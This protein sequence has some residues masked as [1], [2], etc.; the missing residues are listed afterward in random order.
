MEKNNPI[1]TVSIPTWNWAFLLP[2]AV[3]SVLA[4]TYKNFE[5]LIVDDGSTD[6][7]FDTVKE[8]VA[9]D[10]RVKYFYQDNQGPSGA[11]NAGIRKST[12]YYIAFLDSDDEWFPEKIHKQLRLF[13]SGSG[14]GFVGCNKICL[15]KDRDSLEYN[16]YKARFPPGKDRFTLED[17]LKFSSPVN[18]STVMI[19]REA[20]LKTGLFDEKC[21]VHQDWEL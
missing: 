6:N 3:R 18:P 10:G 20:L 16:L 21:L 9:K 12:G 4:Q 7:T 1:V 15:I 13:K 5:L 17:F 19:K 2:V 8:F 11:R 14:L